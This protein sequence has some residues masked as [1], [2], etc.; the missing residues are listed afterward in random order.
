MFLPILLALGLYLGGALPQPASEA[1]AG[2]NYTEI[3]YHLS[4]IATALEAQNRHLERIAAN[5]G[6]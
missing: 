3:E 4:R 6:D 2:S 1:E 5:V